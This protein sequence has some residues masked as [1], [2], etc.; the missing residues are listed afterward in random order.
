M[1]LTNLPTL[2][3]DE[4]E[5][6][7]DGHIAMEGVPAGAPLLEERILSGASRLEALADRVFDSTS[8][9]DRGAA[10]AIRYAANLQRLHEQSLYMR[11]RR[12]VG[13]LVNAWALHRVHRVRTAE[14][15]SVRQERKEVLTPKR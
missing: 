5:A 9:L 1:P 11:L 6:L 15:V 3:D 8:P 4:R 13:A 14:A 10:E 7:D 12:A 2:D